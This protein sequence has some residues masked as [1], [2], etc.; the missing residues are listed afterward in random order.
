MYPLNDN[1]LDR[2]SREAAEQY[3]VDRNPSTSGWEALEGRLNKELP[4]DEKRRRRF[5]F[6]LF[7]IVATAGGG[8]WYIMSGN[9]TD[10]GRIA[11][12]AT[13]PNSNND[14]KNNSLPADPASP[15]T[16]IVPQ[17]EDKPAASAATKPVTDQQSDKPLTDNPSVTSGKQPSNATPEEK[18]QK[19]N[20]K[21]TPPLLHKQKEKQNADLAATDN[22]DS[23][24]L[25]GKKTGNNKAS[26]KKKGIQQKSRDN[27]NDPST[28]GRKDDAVTTRSGDTEKTTDSVNDEVKAST[29]K[30]VVEPV[31]VEPS[32]VDSAV[33]SKAPEAP[34]AAAIP[35]KD[36]TVVAKANALAKTKQ[37]AKKTDN[38]KVKG[39]EIGIVGGPDMS[40]VKFTHA[41]DAGYNIG[42]QLGYRFSNRWSVN[43]GIIYT[44][45]NYEANGKDVA[46]YGYFTRPDVKL[47]TMEGYCT[48]FDFPLNVRY[49]FSVNSK[50]RFYAST[51]LSTYIMKRENYD[52]YYTYNNI[53]QTSNW[54]SKERGFGD[55]TYLFSI[56]NLS[57]G[58]ERALNKHF[59]IQAE[60]YLKLPLSQLGHGKLNLNSYGIYF[61]V[62]Y[63]IAK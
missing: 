10:A 6:W 3:D 37:P 43:T 36:T 29:A 52:Y 47:N 15:N 5:L 19:E 58:F 62:K 34:P 35:A 53:D 1:D 50:R 56:L 61:S 38:K 2:L 18:A 41:T 45:K 59:S 17:V 55:S 32:T 25:T 54:D 46:K 60:P 39:F 16:G 48:M 44:K 27:D 26:N 63:R 51:G 20:K 21:V 11:H 57:A 30:P 24:N 4:V 9:D 13:I 7:F 22:S 8:L 23:P 28:R 40:N 49:D 12:V 14:A 31:T 33:V 42:L